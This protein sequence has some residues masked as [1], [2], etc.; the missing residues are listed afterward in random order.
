MSKP[1]WKNNGFGSVCMHQ[2]KMGV[3]YTLGPMC[4][5]WEVFEYRGPAPDHMLTTKGIAVGLATEEIARQ[6]GSAH[7]ALM[8]AA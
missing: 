1:E 2:G 8:E 5:N 4:D 3:A 7:F 6:I